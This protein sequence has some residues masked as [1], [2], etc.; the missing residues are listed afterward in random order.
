MPIP[1]PV[2]ARA[3]PPPLPIVPNI[4]PSK[5]VHLGPSNVM[6]HSDIFPFLVVLV[7][8]LAGLVVARGL[9]TGLARRRPGRPVG[10]QTGDHSAACATSPDQ[11]APWPLARFASERIP[12]DNQ[13]LGRTAE[14]ASAL[15]AR[16]SASSRS[17]DRIAADAW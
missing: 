13:L 1:Y 7:V 3:T 12:F 17:R 4:A 5:S 9:R 14:A 16:I 10:G 6:L 15:V 8:V 2:A 11:S